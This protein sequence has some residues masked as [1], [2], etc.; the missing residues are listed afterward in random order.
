MRPLGEGAFSLFVYAFGAGLIG[1][2]SWKRKKK[3]KKE[4]VSPTFNGP[5]FMIC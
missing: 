2:L 3:G 5:P 1:L 4:L